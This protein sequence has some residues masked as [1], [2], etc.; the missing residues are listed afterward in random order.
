MTTATTKTLG[1]LFNLTDPKAKDVPFT[2]RAPGPMTPKTKVGYQFVQDHIRRMLLWIGGV[3]GRNLLIAGP[4]QCGKTSL[5][6]QL[7]A[8]LGFEVFRVPCHGKM[9][10]ADLIGQLTIMESGATQFVLGPLPRAMKAGGVL[11]LDEVNYV[12]P[13]VLGALNTVLDGGSLMILETGELIEPS[14]DFRIAATG[15]AVAHGDDA[16]LYRGVQRMNLAFLQR[17]CVVKADYMGKQDECVA[18][19]AAV[20]GL[21]GKV[22]EKMV[23]VAGDVRAVFKEGGIETTISTGVLIKWGNVLARRAVAL[24][25]NPEAELKFALQFVLTDGL[26]PDDAIAVEQTLQRRV[27][28]MKLAQTDFPAVSN[29]AVTAG[30]APKATAKRGRKPKAATTN[31]VTTTVN[32]MVNPDR[33][34]TGNA[35]FWVAVYPEPGTSLGYTMNGSIT[36]LPTTRTVPNKTAGQIDNVADEKRSTRGYVYE[37]RMEMPALEV[38]AAIKDAVNALSE[39]I[40]NRPAKFDCETPDGCDIAIAIGKQMNLPTDFFN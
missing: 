31:V 14:P 21:P 37:H 16:T 25:E 4:T 6:E 13:S 15:N 24:L 10:Y 7:C 26:K 28:G 20:P 23:D 36:P 3:A 18:L 1:E 27:G 2:V 40:A 30:Q 5:V 19:H 39:A 8:R 11:L 29:V 9:E 12:H 17:F 34:K 33:E 38:E 35:T 32:F 22:I